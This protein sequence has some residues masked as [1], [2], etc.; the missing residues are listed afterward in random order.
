MPSS[1]DIDSFG[2]SFLD[3][4]SPRNFVITSEAV[5]SESSFEFVILK[6]ASKIFRADLPHCL[7]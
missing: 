7:R 6:A 4:V 1:V 3:L 2:R 5:E